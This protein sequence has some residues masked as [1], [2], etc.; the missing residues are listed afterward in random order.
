MQNNMLAIKVFGTGMAM[1]VEDPK[2]Q[3]KASSTPEGA[4]VESGRPV[5]EV[6]PERPTV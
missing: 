6:I 2:S 5:E 4:R 1:R 3:M